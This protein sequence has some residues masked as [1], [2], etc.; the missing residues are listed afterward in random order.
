MNTLARIRSRLA[1]PRVLITLLALLSLVIGWGCMA[2]ISR[3][4]AWYR[5]ADSDL[6]NLVDALGIN[7]NIPPAR[8]DQPGF[9]S[10]Y[11]LALDFRA[12]HYAGQLPV[13]NLKKLAGS[14]EPLAEI[15][16]LVHLERQHSRSLVILFILSTGGMVYALTKN[17]E[18]GC[19]AVSLLGG[20]AGLLYHGL[21]NRPDLLAAWFGIVAALFCAWRATTSPTSL[22]HHLW[23]L[24]AGLCAGLSCL[25]LLPGMVCFVTL[26]AWCWLAAFARESEDAAP[27]PGKG[28]LLP[29][30][31][32]AS[33]AAAI[34]CLLPC[35]LAVPGVLSNAA[36][37]R[38]RLLA[39]AAGFL[40]LLGLW[41]IRGRIWSFLFDRGRELALLLAGGLAALALGWVAL[42]AV[43]DSGHADEYLAG[44]VQLVFNPEPRLR[45][46]FG[47][48]PNVGREFMLFIKDDPSLFACGLAAG[49]GLWFARE[50]PFR[51]KALAGLLLVQAVVLGLLLARHAY[52]EQVSV[53]MQVPLILAAVLAI[54]ALAV[55]APHGQVADRSSWATPVVL[56]VA[57][58]V[59]LTV[60]LRLEVK[61]PAR[62]GAS[63][64][65]V[66]D[67]ALT[68]LYDDAAHPREFR[69]LMRARY[70]NRGEFAATLER[71]LAD[72]ANRH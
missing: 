18:S 48:A 70:G 51:F 2:T 62:A 9:P 14:P 6:R 35:L 26:Y 61:Y 42:R 59:V 72:P 22:G 64:L 46:Y 52:L 33:V 65:P 8:I 66:G 47:A 5:N 27:L 55:W 30:F 37:G 31:L 21:L 12:R 60:F 19:L 7:A 56:T 11:L 68:Y 53:F 3:R 38:L 67:A 43:M 39:L 63:D 20:S 40:P 34:F 1:Q 58:V 24:G 54:H 25:T 4:A 16:R 49:I 23:L 44:V 13:W 71:F 45:F 17:Y 36:A 41:S 10:K 50:V 57:L 28:S 15:A 29:A 32:P 69:E